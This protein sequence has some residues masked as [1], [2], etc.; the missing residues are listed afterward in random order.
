MY[1]TILYSVSSQGQ[2]MFLHFKEC[3]KT[4]WKIYFQQ[5][6]VEDVK[7]AGGN[8]GLSDKNDDPCDENDDTTNIENTV[9]MFTGKP[10]CLHMKAE[11]H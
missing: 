4:F 2:H 10:A 1:G 3:M 7:E 11:I 8:D 9:D 5:F 6:Q